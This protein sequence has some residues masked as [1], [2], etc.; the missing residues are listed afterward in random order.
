MAAILPLMNGVPNSVVMPFSMRAPLKPPA[1]VRASPSC[2]ESLT[3]YWLVTVV[4]AVRKSLRNGFFSRSVTSG[5][6]VSLTAY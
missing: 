1:T 6:L 3:K 5:R 2:H 4:S